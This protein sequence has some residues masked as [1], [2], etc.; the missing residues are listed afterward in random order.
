MSA[1]LRPR[2]RA[3]RLAAI[4]AALGACA[5]ALAWTTG[6]V[7]PARFGPDTL[8]D[9]MQG[10]AEPRFPGFRRAHARG[11]CVEGT[12]LSEG[13]LG[14]YS[15]AQALAPGRT[16]LI[17]RYS[18]GGGNPAAPEAAA[19]VRSLALVLT[20]A[21]GQQWRMAMNTPPVL[22]VGTP[23]AFFAQMQA[24]APDP[25][26]GR[27]DPARVEAFF[28]A[29]PHAAAFRAWQASQVPTDSFA[30]TP[31][32]GLH[33]FLLEDAEGRRQPVRFSLVPEAEARPLGEGPHAEDA[34]SAEL[35]ARLASGPVRYR[36]EA[37]FAEPGDPI[38]D[39][40]QAWPE[41]RRR[42]A[43]GIVELTAA[44]PQAG[45][46]CDGMNIDPTVLPTGIAPS[47]DPILAARASAYAESFRRRARETLTG[48]T[49]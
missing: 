6:I 48:A 42:V 13:A 41:D 3:L 34:L 27:P 14:A 25:A 19:G 5:F 30:S 15:T 47:A 17:G 39:P 45:G 4:A 40:S 24:L 49:P 43:A 8:V 35:V 12:F 46:A 9:A 37:V 32:H 38:D 22:A 20:Q 23:E 31:V 2:Q 10:G 1:P 28:A 33:A 16:P 18:I 21:D 44:T 11:L 36:L 26:T 7:G 29:Q